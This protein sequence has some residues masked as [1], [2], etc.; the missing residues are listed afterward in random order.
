MRRTSAMQSG[1]RQGRKR[2][3]VC[4]EHQSDSFLPFQMETR[5]LAVK[6]EQNLLA[7]QAGNKNHNLCWSKMISLL[8]VTEL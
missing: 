7:E 4:Q 2:E 3:I 6:E 1:S 8:K 5:R